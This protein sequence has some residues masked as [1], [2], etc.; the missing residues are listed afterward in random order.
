MSDQ[1]KQLKE[2]IENV[3]VGLY[4]T[5]PEGRIILA[6]PALID[7][8]GFDSLE[9]LKKREVGDTLVTIYQKRL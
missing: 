8:V 9:E 1:G 3:P 7:L 5:T 6:N 2:D 4:R